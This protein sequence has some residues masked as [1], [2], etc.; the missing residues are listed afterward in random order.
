ME[1]ELAATREALETALIAQEHR[2]LP[3]LRT[4]AEIVF[5]RRGAER[6]RV[7]PAALSS[8]AWCL[9]P[10]PGTATVGIVA[11]LTLFVTFQQARLLAIQNDKVEIQNMLAEAQRRASLAVEITAIFERLDREKEEAAKDQLGACRSAANRR[12]WLQSEGEPPQLS[13]VPTQA[14]IGRIAALTQAMR[15]YRYLTVEGAAPELCPQA[16]ASPTLTRAYTALL[17]PIAARGPRGA[18]DGLAPHQAAALLEPVYRGDG[19]PQG[20][21]LRGLA[22]RALSWVEQAAGGSLT[23]TQLNCAPASP[24]RGQ[25]LVSL[26]AAGIELNVIQRAGAD[27]TFADIPGAN[28]A[29]IRLETFDLAGA[30]LPGANLTGATLS[31][32]SFRGADL[33]NARFANASLARSDFEG[34]RLQAY[35][36]DGDAPLFFMPR[37]AQDNQLSGVRLFQESRTPNIVQRLCA[38]LALAA[39]DDLDPALPSL[40]DNA[41]RFGILVETRPGRDGATRQEAVLVHDLRLPPQVL[42]RAP[43]GAVLEYRGLRDCPRG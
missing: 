14:T 27:F 30:R 1:A 41:E 21:W 18:Q 29:G 43:G 35:L 39:A 12:C 40:R 8:V 16:T 4:L 11:L 24:E 13:F 7:L 34:A 20:E 5:Q 32:V 37:V 2:L 36:R 33:G 17:A 3:A 23:G 42:H 26:H 15:P 38:T 19:E 28:L 10:S 9:L 25:L 6:W 22:A 31:G